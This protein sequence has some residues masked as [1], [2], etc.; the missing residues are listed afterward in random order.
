[1]EHLV[2]VLD[3][4]SEEL[5]SEIMERICQLMMVMHQITIT[6]S[7]ENSEFRCIMMG[8]TKPFIK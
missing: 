6:F 4:E 5:T 7:K 3:L 1:M 8:T 2:G